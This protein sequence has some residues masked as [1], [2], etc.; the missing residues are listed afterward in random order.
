MKDWKK[1]VL[2]QAVSRRACQKGIERLT[3]CN[4][5]SDVMQLYRREADWAL[6]ND[7]PSLA[8][9]RQLKEARLDLHGLYIDRKFDGETLWDRQVYILRNCKGT[10]KTG[11]NIEQRI[12]P[13]FYIADG[14]DITIESA[15][16]DYLTHPITV[17]IWLYGD[18]HITCTTDKLNCTIHK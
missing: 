10:I 16:E 1:Q 17:P 7:V 2:T 13:I 4:S 12:S 18:S 3:D 15:N 8:L 11:L 6:E 9:L 5:I 14:S